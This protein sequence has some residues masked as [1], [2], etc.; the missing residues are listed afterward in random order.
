MI[1]TKQLVIGAADF[2]KGVSTSSDV[3]DGGF[4]PETD[5]VN[6]TANPGTM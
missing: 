4:S 5:N 6:L 1:G 3:S 2:V